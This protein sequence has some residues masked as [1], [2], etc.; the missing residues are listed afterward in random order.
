MVMVKCDACLDDFKHLI[1]AIFFLTLNVSVHCT[2]H[3]ERITMNK[4]PTLPSFWTSATFLVWSEIPGQNTSNRPFEPLGKSYETDCLEMWRHLFRGAAR[5]VGLETDAK[6]KGNWRNF[7]KITSKPWWLWPGV[8][9]T[10]RTH[11]VSGWRMN[12]ATNE[13]ATGSDSLPLKM[14]CVD[15]G[16]ARED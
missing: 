8:I 6:T 16:W 11:W 5:R 4:S 7:S 12:P 3:C 13:T 9:V 10:W 15:D 2:E 1:S 14:Q